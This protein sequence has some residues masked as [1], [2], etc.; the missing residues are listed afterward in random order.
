[1]LVSYNWLQE[2]VPI[3]VSPEELGHRLT[4]AG[5]ELAGITRVGANL[6]NIF[7]AQ[8]EELSPHPHA[9][10]LSVCRVTDGTTILN[11]VC[12]ATNMKAGDK[13]ALAR[14]G[15]R[16]P[17]GA[18]I[19]ISKIRGVTSEGMLCSEEELTLEEQSAGIMILPPEAELG[20]DIATALKLKD[21]V[22][23]IDLTP[24]R[25]DCL[26]M[27]GIAREAAALF[28][29]PLVLPPTRLS[30]AED[31]GAVEQYV[32]VTIED[33][34]FC[35]RYTARYV[36]NVAIK[37]SP[38]WLRRRLEL[39]G[40]RAIN[41]VVDITNYILLTW[42]QPMHAFDY[43]LLDQGRIIVKRASAGECFCTLDG[44]ERILDNETLMICD[45]SKKIAIAGIMGGLNTEIVSSTTTVL[46]ESAYFNP[47]NIRR[48]S[49]KLGLKSESSLRFEKGVDPE[50]VIPALNHAA[51]LMV[52]LADGTI[53]RGVIDAYPA[54]ISPQPP[55]ELRPSRAALILGVDISPEEAAGYLDRLTISAEPR[56]HDTL[57]AQVP[58]YRRD[59]K[60]EIDLIEEIARLHGYENI[61]VTL[62]GMAV[63]A[64]DEKIPF[65]QKEVIR[66]LLAHYGFF[67]IITYS[68][69]AP[70]DIQ[71]L[72]LSDDHIMRQCLSLSNPLSQDQSVMRT[73]LLPGLLLTAR[74][75]HYQNIVNL[76]LFEM[77]R[78]FWP[79]TGSSLPQ[80]KLMLGALLCGRRA[81]EAWNNPT[82]EVDYFDAKGVLENILDCLSISSLT[83]EADTSISYLHPGISAR[84]MVNGDTVGVIGEVHPHVI[85]NFEVSKKIIVFEIDFG[86][87]MNYCC[88]KEKRL[89]PLPKFP[90][91]YRDLALIARSDTES[92]IILETIWRAKAQ[93][94]DEVSVFD[95]YQGEHI[96]AGGK[97][98]GYRLKFQAPDRSLTDEEVNNYYNRIVSHVTASLDVKLR[99]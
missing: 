34:E 9:D 78:V 72:R 66:S 53:A 68:F 63:F 73:T 85:E 74:H 48:T 33:P 77:G 10:R 59:L 87:I 93:Y 42:G 88:V 54:P 11:I 91:V 44:R 18:K 50:A 37:P 52:E 99:T 67:E 65:D 35:P 21:F 46:L 31:G 8:I 75:N 70:T 32:H 23:E 26:S 89:K 80:E 22:L 69:I 29:L 36:S 4:M 84:V 90:A 45:A 16:L 79:D 13:V 81:Q 38:L 19:K 83:F 6:E 96:P 43:S 49:R 92:K 98:L 24:N 58:S 62:P 51:Q 14:G 71:A 41:N 3:D 76:K 12:G 25:A 28:N 82:E 40:I 57:V 64:N 5:L 60:E 47:H 94:L 55:I 61:P 30:V 97:S 1:M 15:T 17:N 86:K 27:V 7:V 39:A 2:L 20:Q 56:D 95:V